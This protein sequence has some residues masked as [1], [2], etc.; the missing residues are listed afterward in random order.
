MRT[1]STRTGSPSPP[2][3]VLIGKIDLRETPLS[4][5][6]SERYRNSNLSDIFTYVGNS[7]EAF[8]IYVETTYALPYAQFTWAI[9]APMSPEPMTTT[10]LMGAGVGHVDEISLFC[11]AAAAEEQIDSRPL[12]RSLD[13]T[14]AQ[15]CITVNDSFTTSSTLSWEATFN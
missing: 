4:P 11:P 8:N 3:W 5:W 12:R 7:K 10:F 2:Q 1:Y 6:K 14:P 15:C 9:P 13:A